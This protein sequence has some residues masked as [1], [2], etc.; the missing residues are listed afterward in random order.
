MTECQGCGA[1]ND[2]TRTL[3]VL[4]GT[5]L[6]E[7]DEWDAA[8]EP[9]PLPPLPD[10]GL[11]TSMPDWLREAPALGMKMTPPS[12]WSAV[13]GAEPSQTATVGATLA[14]P[15]TPAS[16]TPPRAASAVPNPEPIHLGPTA[17][18]RTFLVDEDFPQWLREL[19]ARNAPPFSRAA[20][21]AP[22]AVPDGPGAWPNWPEVAA[23]SSERV[24]VPPTPA[25]VEPQVPAASPPVIEER[26]GQNVWETVLLVLLFIGVVAAA[27][28]ALVSNGVFSAGL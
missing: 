8:A 6:A 27:I 21:P 20:V 24:L 9:P 17:D 4:C 22:A 16:P 28:W 25:P 26:R 13:A 12:E 11:A 18:P 14:S 15:S 10:G 2:T 7:T 19:A 23:T 1:W 5:P 3:C